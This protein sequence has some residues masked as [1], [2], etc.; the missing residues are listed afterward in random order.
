MRASAGLALVALAELRSYRDLQSVIG[1][2]SHGT[3]IPTEPAKDDLH[4]ANATTEE[5]EM[6][7]IREDSSCRRQLSLYVRRET[8]GL[9]RTSSISNVRYRQPVAWGSSERKDANSFT[10]SNERNQKASNS[11]L[12]TGSRKRP[13][14]AQCSACWVKT[15]RLA[16]NKTSHAHSSLASRTGQPQSRYSSGTKFALT[17]QPC[18]AFL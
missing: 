7:S 4:T 18:S 16:R 9:Q 6:I 5:K 14:S 15:G 17:S 2:K 10:M 8:N 1:R 12:D 3:A 13:L 11:A